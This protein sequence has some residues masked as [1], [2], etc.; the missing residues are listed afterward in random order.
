MAHPFPIT[1]EPAVL[2]D[3]RSRLQNTRYT[4]SFNNDKWKKGTNET[5][6]KELCNYWAE[7]FDWKKQ[8]VYLNMFSHFKTSIDGTGIH[9]I[10]EKGKGSKT[11]PLLLI[12]GFPDSFVRFLK[13]IPL[14]TEADGDG[15]SFDLVIPSL[16]GFGFSDIPHEPGMNQQRM[17]GLF[18]KLMKNELG[19]SQ[20]IVHGGDWGSS[21]TEQIA[22]SNSQDLKGIHLTD[23]PWYHLFTIPPNDLTEAEKEYLQAGQQWSK[24]EG[25]YG[26]IQSTRPQSLGYG[27]NDSPAGL[28]GWII[29]MFYHWSDCNGRLENVFTKDE[30]LTNLTIYWATQTINSAINLYY[31]AA[32][33]LAQESKKTAIKKVELPTAVAIF[34]KDLVPAPRAFAERIFNIQQWT[35][36]PAGGHFAAMEQPA[37]LANDI[38]LFAK[39]LK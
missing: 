4:H 9:Y 39:K 11:I 18:A 1:I 24:T 36:M 34:P 19:Y 20:F 6:L 10:H 33:L 35:E 7:G 22:L 29:E 8:E 2:N 14:L 26:M 37:L 27:L 5:W 28:A 25:A 12:H 30:L 16:P 32:V 17:A 21:I 31:E 13:I 3:L 23:I 15:F 38:R